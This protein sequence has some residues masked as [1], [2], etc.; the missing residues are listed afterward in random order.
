MAETFA[1]LA[2]RIQA[3]DPDITPQELE[4]LI[5]DHVH[6][7]I[8]D[9]AEQIDNS[10]DMT[11]IR[12]AIQDQFGLYCEMEPSISIYVNIGD[13]PSKNIFPAFSTVK[14]EQD[15]E[16]IIATSAGKSVHDILDAVNTAINNICISFLHAVIFS[17][18]VLKQIFLHLKNVHNVHELTMGI[19]EPVKIITGRELG[20]ATPPIRPG[21]YL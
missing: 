8:T 18:P 20:E 16:A 15:L 21:M 3:G 13:T 2:Q 17:Q 4:K 9:M 6:E 7:L 11:M 5:A 1:T 12:Q 14:L 10:V 19:H